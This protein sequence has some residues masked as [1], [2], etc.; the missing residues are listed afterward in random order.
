MAL[1]FETPNAYARGILQGIGEYI[2]THGPWVVSFV[3]F[4]LNDRPPAWLS[5]W[6]GQG[7]IFRGENRRMAQAVARLSTPTVDM[8]P[9]RLLPHVPWVKS[10]DAAVARMA[11][12]H[13]LERGFRNFAFCGNPDFN[14]SN[15]RREYFKINIHGAGYVCRTFEQ[16]LR[17]RSADA[18]IDA[19]AR[20][21]SE[22][23][24]PV[25]VFAYNDHEGQQVLDACRRAGLAVPEEVAVLGVDNDEVLCA[26]S[27]PP[28][29]SVI[30][31]PR[32]G[33]WDAAALLRVMMSGEEVP[34]TEY[35]IPPV[36]I[37]VR[38]STDVLAVSDPQIAKALRFIREHA[39]ERIGVKHVLQ[40]CPMARRA[41]EMRF[42]KLLGRSPHEEIVRVQLNRV[43]E[44]LV[45]TQLSV[46]EIADRTGF[47]PEYISVVFKQQNGMTPTEFRKQF[48]TVQQESGARIYPP[49]L[50]R[51]R[52]DVS[53]WAI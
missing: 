36:S 9:S 20:W 31:N 26:L 49:R 17:T 38:Q 11:A 51:G 2:L 1:L 43:K 4:G 13:F 18:R 39:C 12:A 27:P 35:F 23:P 50:V 14:V 15:R 10:D 3:V 7:I 34:V 41:L 45:G 19:I 47:D 25:G 33:G 42:K 22:L 53:E 16:N 48:G 40:H 5:S 52:S 21:L 6:D 29:S 46:A 24:R 28:M 37:A 30:L 32:R 44:L 8:T